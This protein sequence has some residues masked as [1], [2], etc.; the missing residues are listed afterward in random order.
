MEN[1]EIHCWS[2]H[3]TENARDGEIII[4]LVKL[5]S[6][7]ISIGL[8]YILAR[9]INNDRVYLVLNVRDRNN[10]TLGQAS[11]F[12]RMPASTGTYALAHS[13]Q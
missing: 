5:I 2:T 13:I 7:Q 1:K 10:T 6:T 12:L 8:P 9:E 3:T 11:I 4:R